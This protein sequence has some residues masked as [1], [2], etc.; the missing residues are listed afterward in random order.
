MYWQVVCDGILVDI[1]VFGT[2]ICLLFQ[3][4][5]PKLVLALYYV[6]LSRWYLV[7]FK[8]NIQARDLKAVLLQVSASNGHWSECGAVQASLNIT[9][10]V[11][12]LIPRKNSSSLITTLRC[13][14]GNFEHP[15]AVVHD[16][17]FLFV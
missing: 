12:T 6:F 17:M 15:A 7:Q 3:E 8:C 16:E 14:L 11:S 13:L 2:Q 10:M 4:H 9:C 1:L 5:E